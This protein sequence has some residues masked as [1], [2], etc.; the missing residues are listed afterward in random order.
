MVIVREGA[1]CCLVAKMD[2]AKLITPYFELGL[3][4][5]DIL[6]TLAKEHGIII[7]R[8]TLQRMLKMMKLCRRQYSDIGNVNVFIHHEL[9]ESYGKCTSETMSGSLDQESK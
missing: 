8:R 6:S 9:N 2:A 7:S 3:L 1:L 4:Q 5:K